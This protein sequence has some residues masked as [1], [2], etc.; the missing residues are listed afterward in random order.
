MAEDHHADRGPQVAGVAASF[1]ALCWIAIGLRCYCRLVIVKS[2][3]IDDYLAV[4]AQVCVLLI[5]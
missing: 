5:I 3:G 2:F 1:L 4:A